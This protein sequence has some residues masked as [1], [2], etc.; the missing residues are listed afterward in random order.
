MSRKHIVSALLLSLLAFTQ[1]HAQ[2]LLEVKRVEADSLVSFIRHEIAQ[3]VYIVSSDVDRASLTVSAPRQ[4]FLE[5]AF[6]ELRAKGYTISEYKGA[7]FVSKSKALA[8]ELPAGFFSNGASQKNDDLLKYITD[9]NTVVTFQNKVYE[10]GDLV[11]GRTSGKFTVSGYVRDVSTGEPL[12]GVAVYDDATGAYSLT[13]AY[14][15]YRIKLP[16]GEGVLNFSG[17]SMDDLHLN[18]IVYGDGGLDV[19]MKEKVT[20]LKGAVVSAEGRSAHRDARMGIERI[21]VSE[22]AKVPAVFGESDVLKV[23]LTLP[24]VKT[25][26]EAATGFNVRGGSVDQNLIL[27]NDGTVYNPSHMFGIMSAFNTDV[28]NE[29]ELY[30]SS[31]PAEFGGRISSVL[32][33]RG[34]EGNSKKITGSVGLGLLTS[35]LNIEGPIGKKTTFILGGRTTYSNWLLNLLPD[36]SGYA[37][38]KASF[39]DLNLGVSHRIND[40]NSIHAY[41][42]W[43]RDSFSFSGDTAFHYSNL[44]ASLKWRSTLSERHTMELTAG[45]DHYGN[46]LDNT[47]NA[48][49]SYSLD[50]DV[51]QAFLKLAF[52]A[53]AGEKHNLK[54]G[55]N[56][57]AYDLHP[58]ILNPLGEYSIVVSRS[59]DVQ[60]ALE[61]ALYLSDTWNVS[62]KLS[63]DYG[64]RLSAFVG[65]G[66]KGKYAGPELRVSG[67]YSF[68]PNF[69]FKAGFNS[70]KQYIHL[71]SNSSSISPMDTWTLSSDRIRPQDGWQG[72][73]GLYWT[74]A[75]QF[76]LSIEGYYKRMWNY[77]DYKS[78]A[79]L[80]MNEN[81]AD[82]LVTTRGKA[83]GAELMLKKSVGK[84]NGW[85]SYTYSRAFL[86]EMEDRGVE[87]IN[88][89]AWYSAPHDKPHDFKFVGNYKFTHRYSLSVNVDYSTGRPVT[90]PIGYYEYG[91]GVRL[92]YSDRNG[93]RI[94]DYFRLDLAMN[95]EPGHYLKQLTHMSVTFGVYNVTGRRNAYSVYYTTNGGLMASGHMISVFATQVPYI[96]LNLKF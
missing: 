90:I 88:S 12:T 64:A 54:Y 34:R 45:I 38:G 70:M 81:L 31:I 18:V 33:I 93:Y 3:K 35:R 52:K 86:Q 65:M 62:D 95:I 59:L 58:G 11:E 28:I 48:W 85:L 71:L 78:G 6:E 49:E 30:K 92:A 1:L 36:D 40:R 66:G 57:I 89:G 24:G 44:N 15:L 42:Y 16:F 10:I 41:G 77:L 87:T 73:S 32:D 96:N 46:T 20:S 79:T 7:W 25:A 17:Y 39:S 67:K 60:N 2:S 22:I 26:G 76:E 27:F 9:Q 47:F 51:N 68:S 75:D 91:G 94:P 56:L 4:E 14:G 83:Y 21:R 29:V 50:T 23:V 43:S 82:D 13:D 19:V 5:K 53:M 72:A 8:R 84:L 69:S 80:S 74:I 61:P 37:G 55:L 63:L